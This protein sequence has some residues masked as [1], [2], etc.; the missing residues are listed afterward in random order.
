MEKD[1]IENKF[2]RDW[3]DRKSDQIIEKVDHEAITTQ[4][5]MVL[6]LRSLFERFKYIDHEFERIDKRFER[7][8]IKFRW[9]IGLLIPAFGGIYLKL[10]LM[11]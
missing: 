6:S 2:F 3:L 11:N 7:M 5:M 1:L 10:F 8:D 9:L 4:E